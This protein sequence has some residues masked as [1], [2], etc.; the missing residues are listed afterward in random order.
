MRISDAYIARTSTSRLSQLTDRLSTLQTQVS[1]GLRIQQ[2]SDDPSGAVRAA[3]LH[4]GLSRIDQYNTA[5]DAATGW[6]KAEDSALG[7][8]TDTLRSAYDQGLQGANATSTDARSTLADSLDSL[9]NT[10]VQLGNTTYDGRY[11]FGGTQTTTPP[12]NGAPGAVSYTGDDTIRQATVGEGVQVVVN[13]PGSTVMG[14]NTQPDVFATLHTLATA[15]RNNDQ[16]AITNGVQALNTNLTRITNLRG[17]TGERLQQ[18]S[19]A[20]DHLSSSKITLNSAVDDVEG[21][22]ITQA[23]VDLKTQE[24]LYT[25]ASYVSSTLGRGGL[26]QWLR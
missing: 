4:S 26:L 25:A 3:Q 16:A 22:D 21:V 7:Q 8:I 18:L 1:S 9:S 12:F 17:D 11:L 15:L 14:T 13:Q 20:S 24:N 10:L 5:T 19:L 2:A 23:I 6:V